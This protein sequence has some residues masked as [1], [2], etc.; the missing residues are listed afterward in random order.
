MRIRRGSLLIL[1]L[2][3]HPYSIYYRG[4]KG[5]LGVTYTVI[6]EARGNNFIK[7]QELDIP[8]D[9]DVIT[10]INGLRI[11]KNEDLFEYF[12]RYF[13][14]ASGIAFQILRKGQFIDLKMI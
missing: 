1:N 10:E 7:F 12:D 2:E 5:L 9:G 8:L 14:P 11:T 4:E 6:V 13:K 3:I